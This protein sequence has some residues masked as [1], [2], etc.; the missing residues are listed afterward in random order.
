MSVNCARTI[1]ITGIRSLRFSL[2]LSF[3]LSLLIGIRNLKW[4]RRRS[5]KRICM[6]TG[7][8]DIVGVKV[9][10]RMPGRW[11]FIP[12]GRGDEDKDQVGPQVSSDCTVDEP[13]RTSPNR[14]RPNRISAI[15]FRAHL[16]AGRPGPG[17]HPP[18]PPHGN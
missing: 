18:D 10:E 9:L 2:S 6:R 12:L 16:S 13:A 3:S 15:S 7:N 14:A 4:R 17:L 1:Y 11:F 5:K 8:E